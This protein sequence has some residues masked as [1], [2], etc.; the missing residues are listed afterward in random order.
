VLRAYLYT[1]QGVRPGPALLPRT[2]GHPPH[3]YTHTHTHARARAHSSTPQVAEKTR[4][5]KKVW[6]K[7]QAAQA[8]IQDARAEFQREREDYAEELRFLRAQVRLKQLLLENFVP[9]E[10]LAR[11]EARAK[12]DEETEDWVLGRLEL[13]GNRQRQ[14]RPPSTLSPAYASLYAALPM[15]AARPT[16]QHTLAK[17]Q[18][19]SD[20]RFRADNIATMDLEWGNFSQPAADKLKV[21]GLTNAVVAGGAA[22]GG[23]GK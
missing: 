15:P 14:R 19:D 11:L 17:A 10:E 1:L 8:E 22:G 23:G 16:A 2:P 4:K 20:P 9:G 3:L 18:M 6:N 13:A 21:V 7:L 12:W 5:L